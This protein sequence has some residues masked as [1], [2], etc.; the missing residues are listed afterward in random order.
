MHRLDARLRI[1]AAAA[2]SVAV[3]LADRPGA[4]AV[5]LAAGA[6]LALSARL[7]A[8]P[9]GRRMV[10]LNAFMLLLVVLLPVS[11]PGVPL[12]EAGPLSFSREGLLLAATVAVKANA[13]VLLL[14]AM[15]STLEPMTFGRALTALHVPNKLVHLYFFTVRYIDVLHH[16]YGRLRRAMRVRCFRPRMTV[17]TYRSVGYLVGMLLVKSFDR[18][19]RVLAAMKCRGFTGRFVLVDPFALARRDGLF[20]LAAAGLLCAMGL[21]QWT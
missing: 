6:G 5:G 9:V 19:E 7:P 12:L 16:E 10:G 2:G 21:L 11:V 13:I 20:A 18:S 3:A 17:H 8:G 1:I 4:L 14:T 15:L